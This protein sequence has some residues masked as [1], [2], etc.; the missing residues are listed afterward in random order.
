MKLTLNV[1]LCSFSY[2]FISSPKICLKT[3]KNESLNFDT[4][5]IEKSYEKKSLNQHLIKVF[6]A[7]FV[8]CNKYRSIIIPSENIFI[9]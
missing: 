2:P 1:F 4:L 7:F 9:T 5:L 8:L 3:Y 6:P